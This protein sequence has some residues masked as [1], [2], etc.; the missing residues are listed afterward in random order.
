M[1][2]GSKDGVVKIWNVMSQNQL[3]D[4]QIKEDENCIDNMCLK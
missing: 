3:D 1:Y 4:D 2:S